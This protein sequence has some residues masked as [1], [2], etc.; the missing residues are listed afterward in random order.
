MP[1]VAI[2]SPGPHD[3]AI[4]DLQLADRDAPLAPVRVEHRDVLGSE[5]EQRRERG[6]GAALR[7]RLEVAAGQDQRRDDGGDLEIDRVARRRARRDQ[8]E[9]HAHLRQA[10]VE[11]E[12]RDHRPAPGGERADAR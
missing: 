10:R 4:A 3:E 5:L 1:S 8:L 6:A 11:E 7:A 12:E 2:F 9:R